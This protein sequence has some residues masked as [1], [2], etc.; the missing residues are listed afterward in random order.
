VKTAVQSNSQPVGGTT[1]TNP[2]PPAMAPAD[3]ASLIEQM[4]PTIAKFREQSSPQS[5]FLPQLTLGIGINN[6]GAAGQSQL[7]QVGLGYR[8]VTEHVVTAV[9]SNTAGS[10]QTVNFSPLFPYDL[11]GN[12]LVG[13]NGGAAVYSASGIAGIATALRNRKGTFSF[14]TLGGFGPALSP[15]LVRVTVTG[16]GVTVTNSAASSPS[17]SGIASISIPATT[18]VATVTATFYTFEKLALDRESLLGVLPLQNSSTDAV[19]TRSLQVNLTGTTPVFPFYV[20]GSFPATTTVTVQDVINTT[21]EF[22]GIPSDPGLYREMV[23]NSYQVQEAPNKT[24]SATGIEALAYNIPNNQYLVATHLWAFNGDGTLLN[25][26]FLQTIKLT[27]NAG[28]VRPVTLAQGRSRAEEF[29]DYG[30]DRQIMGG[31]RVWDGERTTE[32]VTD[33]DQAGWLDTYSAATPQLLADVSGSAT[34]PITYSVTRESVV[35]GA[36]QVVGG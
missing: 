7:S 5:V 21:Y 25:S 13:I 31:Y 15:A 10:A 27:Y 33:A 3:I 6:L 22:W 35:A 12:Q 17:F 4:T 30:D 32:D 29:L 34:T 18:G 26:A 16:A 36:V 14:S 20:A 24:V 1:A 8:L 23:A 2:V 11:I 9:L 28:A 19:I